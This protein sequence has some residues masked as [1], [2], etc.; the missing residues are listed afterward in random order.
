MRSL[1]KLDKFA[2]STKT[3][4]QFVVQA[5]NANF[6]SL[7]LRKKNFRLQCLSREFY[8]ELGIWV[9]HN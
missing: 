8:S 7:F 5:I 9:Q 1:F 6:S 2:V 4:K 3:L